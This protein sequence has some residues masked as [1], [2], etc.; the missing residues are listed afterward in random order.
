MHIFLNFVIDHDIEIVRWCASWLTVEAC[1]RNS[2]SSLSSLITSSDTR[3]MDGQLLS[4]LFLFNV[5]LINQMVALVLFYYLKESIKDSEHVYKHSN[6]LISIL[7]L[8]SYSGLA[9][10]T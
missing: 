3:A 1:M 5:N 8:R 4:G 9:I 10:S 6:L 2:Y 7:R